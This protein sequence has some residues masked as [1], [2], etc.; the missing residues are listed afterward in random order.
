MSIYV[1]YFEHLERHRG[2][3]QA[4]IEAM[5]GDKRPLTE[6]KSRAGAD[7][8]TSGVSIWG[9]PFKIERN[10]GT[11]VAVYLI[12]SEGTGGVKNTSTS[13]QA[14]NET[15]QKDIRNLM[16]TSLISSVSLYN[17]KGQIQSTDLSVIEEFSKYLKILG[18][19][20]N[21]ERTGEC[22][23]RKPLQALVFLKRDFT[24]FEMPE[25]SENDFVD[26]SLNQNF[27]TTIDSFGFNPGRKCFEK[28]NF[29]E[30]LDALVEK[31]DYFAVP[32]PSEF[33]KD[34]KQYNNRLQIRSEFSFTISPL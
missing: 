21:S 18:H 24:E 6:F 1:R 11:M 9:R 2:N 22:I 8:I 26:G 31:V 4:A 23:G 29:S 17:V 3:H 10:D 34:K 19:Y 27:S 15:G 16:L 5:K 20:N 25:L 7:P 28:K 12:D 33:A 14:L 13:L 30:L 32:E